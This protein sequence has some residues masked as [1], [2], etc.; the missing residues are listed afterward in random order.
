MKG[1]VQ[2]L[3]FVSVFFLGLTASGND[4]PLATNSTKC[5]AAKKNARKA[6]KLYSVNKK[7]AK[8]IQAKLKTLVTN[9]KRMPA[10]ATS[11]MSQQIQKLKKAKRSKLTKIKRY[12]MKH[13][14]FKQSARRSCSKKRGKRKK[15]DFYIK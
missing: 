6:K 12:L 9:Q 10:S 14:Q 5:S 13:K 4:N 2:I 1:I 3:F 15:V 11:N 7:K 8:K